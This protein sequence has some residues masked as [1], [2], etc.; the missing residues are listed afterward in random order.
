MLDCSSNLYFKW[1][2]VVYIQQKNMR[3]EKKINFDSVDSR[4]HSVCSVHCA[5]KSNSDFSAC[6]ICSF[7]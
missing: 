6:S 7:R 3:R 4:P 2:L 1:F 5:P